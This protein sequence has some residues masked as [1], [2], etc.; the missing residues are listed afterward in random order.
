M[1]DWNVLYLVAH[2]LLKN[3]NVITITIIILPCIDVHYSTIVLSHTLDYI[4][5]IYTFCI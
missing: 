3:T 2:N 1:K 4:T 5:F